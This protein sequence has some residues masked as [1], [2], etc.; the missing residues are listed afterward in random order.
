MFLRR[1]NISFSLLF[2][3]II[4]FHFVNNY[5]W[6][7]QTN[8]IVG[9]DVVNNLFSQLKFHHLLSSIISMPDISIFFK[10]LRIVHLVNTPM[11]D[12]NCICWPN[13]V[14]L[15]SSFFSLFFG[16]ALLIVKLTQFIYF[17]I[18][19]LSTYTIAKEITDRKAGLLAMFLVSMYPLVFESSRQYSLDFPLT[20]FVALAINLLLKTN[21]FANLRYSVFL[22]ISCGIAM[23]I[24]GQF[25]LFFIFPFLMVLSRC[26]SRKNRNQF[27]ASI[28]LNIFIFFITGVLISSLWWGNKISS[29]IEG[30]TIHIVSHNKFLESGIP[31]KMNSLAFY[32]F[33]LKA[34]G[35]DSLGI[36]FSSIFLFSLPYF[37]RHK[38][39][40]KS[41]LVNWIF[42]PIM[43]FSVFFVVKHSRFLMPILPAIAIVSACGIQVINN[44]KFKNSIIFFI[45]LF[46]L[47]QYYTLSYFVKRKVPYSKRDWP[48]FGYSCYETIRKYEPEKIRVATEIVKGINNGCNGLD[49]CKVG[50]ANVVTGSEIVYWLYSLNPKLQ[51]LDW[52]EQYRY[53][54]SKG[55]V[56][57]NYLIFITHKDDNL[58]WPKGKATVE[59]WE[60]NF[61]KARFFKS[62]ADW[63]DNFA[64]LSACEPEFELIKTIDSYDGIIRYLYKRKAK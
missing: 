14:F 44:R 36:I 32:L 62:L 37:S 21:Y 30:L 8:A 57:M 55:L 39:K 59:L 50:I 22:G 9:I 60:K 18:L 29:T 40:Y 28:L 12:P 11:F 38:I 43:V 17:F 31:V 15:S 2:I 23:L 56:E 26:L 46:G 19:F 42:I 33:H 52:L 47:I 20:A 63:D 58:Y 1:K 6:L 41:L 7:K 4:F 16:N 54:F 64:K 34:L 24:K 49:D 48:I 53:F 3:S 51:I 27:S 10:I 13:F 35:F 61:E 45:I 25:I 5:L